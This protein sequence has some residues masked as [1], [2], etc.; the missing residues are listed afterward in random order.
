LLSR[1]LSRPK[2]FT[3]NEL[4]HL[5][6]GFGYEEAISGKTSGSRV[7][8]INHHTKHI[9]RLHKPHPAPVLKRYQVEAIIDE[10]TRMGVIP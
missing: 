8:F 10:L 2:D 9:I 6:S 3:Y 1:L 5:L 4:K 7:A